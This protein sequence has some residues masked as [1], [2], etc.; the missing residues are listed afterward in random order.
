MF[1][2]S[3]LIAINRFIAIT[4]PIKYKYYFNTKHIHIYFLI[5]TILGI[6]IGAIGASYPS[7]YIF[8]LQMNRIV[9]IYL[10]SNNI[11]FHSAVA[12]FLN[13]P[14]IIVTTILNFICLYKNKQ[15]FH[16][17][18]LN[19]KTMEFKMLVYSIFL[20]TIM[21]AF[22]LYYMSKSLPII[23]NDFEYLQSIAIQ[24]LPWI[25]DLMTFGIFFISLTLS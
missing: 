4:K 10:D 12:I 18:D 16:K 17:R 13:L 6:I 24:A 5:I 15:L 9:A 14:L 21:I 19:V 20:M 11:Y 23:M 1:Q 8:S 25:I 2:I 3:L 7:Q 22:E